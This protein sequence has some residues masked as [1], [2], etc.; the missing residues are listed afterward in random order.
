[1]FPSPPK[2]LHVPLVILLFYRKLA[3]VAYSSIDHDLLLDIVFGRESKSRP[4][5]KTLQWLLMSRVRIAVGLSDLFTS[6][7][8]SI[9]PN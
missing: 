5:L 8:K 4:F 9:Q 7:S 1:M 3:S 2:I 6:Y